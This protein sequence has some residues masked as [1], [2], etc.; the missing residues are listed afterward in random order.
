MK[1]LQAHNYYRFRGG[2]DSMYEQICQ[3]LEARGHDVERYERRSDAIQGA[4]AKLKALFSGVYSAQSKRE[5]AEVL[6]RF[7]PDLVHM[8]NPYPLISPSVLEACGSRQIP[9]VMRCPNYRLICPTALHLRKGKPCDLCAGGREYWCALTN[10]RGNLLEST[11][12][13]MRS[14]AVRTQGLIQKHVTLFIPPSACVKRHLVAAGIPA[15][16]VEVV[17]NTVVV[18]DHACAPASGEYVVFA[19]RLS[20]E[21]GVDTLLRAAALLPGVPVVIAGEGALFEELKKDATPNVRFTGKLER[22]ALDELYAGARMCVVPSVWDEAFGLVA[23]EASAM[24]LPVVA[25]RM[26]A[27]PEIIDDEE[28][29]LLFE[30]GNETDLAEKIEALWSHPGRCDALGQA[31]REKVRRE[32]AHDVYYERLMRV[33][34]RATGNPGADNSESLAQASNL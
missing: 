1:V 24:G 11:A 31:G 8:H 10:C 13:G 29:G 7:H 12:M 26:G 32:Y 5:M 23:A 28:T 25:S 20:E 4:P 34:G 6:D 22:K 3:I 27:L 19:G 18:P 9:V 21:K 2:E 14:Y 16:K 17:P 30:S 15:D 33:Y